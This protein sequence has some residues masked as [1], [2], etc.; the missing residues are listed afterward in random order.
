M[1]N[2]DAELLSA[3]YKNAKTGYHSTDALLPKASQGKFGGEL[4]S[5]RDQYQNFAKDASQRLQEMELSPKE[6]NPLSRLSMQV[7]IA[8][9]T[10][11]DSSPSHLAEMMINGS[12]MG[13][14]D[15]EKRLKQCGESDP[16]VQRLG[17]D[18]LEFEQQSIDRLKGDPR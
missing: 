6:P 15:L 5:C 11:L 17:K 14:I 1:M 13:I 18:L 7:G 4:R 3:I 10:M 2:K 12:T 9:N 16:E 8:A